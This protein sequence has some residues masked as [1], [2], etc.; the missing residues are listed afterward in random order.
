MALV[1]VK[2]TITSSIK[3]VNEDRMGLGWGVKPLLAF[4]ETYFL[5]AFYFN[6]SCPIKL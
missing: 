1:Q 5:L 3:Y 4:N 2:G 6:E